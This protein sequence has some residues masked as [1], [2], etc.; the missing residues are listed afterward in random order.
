[1]TI[2]EIYD[3]YK[4]IAIIQ[5]LE[6]EGV[7]Y[8]IKEVCHLS[9]TEMVLNYDKKLSI[10]EEKI[11]IDDLN[12]YLY[13]EVPPQYVIG[14]TYFYGRKFFV[15]SDVLIPRYDTEVVV[16]KTLEIIDN[17]K[18]KLKVLDVGTGSGC[19]AITLQK[20]CPKLIVDAVDISLDAL[21][22][23]SKNAHINNVKVNFYQS[24]LL[25]KV[26]GK[27]DILISNP[28]YISET[29]E[30]DNI[31]STKEPSI[32]LFAEDDGMIYYKKIL[33]ES[34]R[35]LKNKNKIIFEIAYNKKDKIISLVKKYYPNA[36]IKI[37]K[38]LAGNDRVAIIEN[39]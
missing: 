24:D 17:K 37:E 13:E 26:T 22:V 11:L 32:A 21:E 29:D 2:K 25:S 36:L 34:S 18:A 5:D 1:M 9:E 39:N 14:Y 8:I 6:I 4:D 7:K 15:N 38:D 31:V 33:E 30:V 16:E 23:A 19:I 10:I 35:I 20:E 12:E 28:P 27:F 3:K